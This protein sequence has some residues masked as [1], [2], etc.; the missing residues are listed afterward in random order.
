M[1]HEARQPLIFQRA[2]I[3]LRRRA[4][5]RRSTGRVA[6]VVC[7]LVAIVR[8][9]GPSA[10]AQTSACSQPTERS[11]QSHAWAIMA[12][13]V[14]RVDAGACVLVHAPPRT[15]T[16]AA[17][18]GYVQFA[19]T[20][21]E[22]PVALAA[23]ENTVYVVFQQPGA[24]GTTEVRIRSLD[25]VP[26]GLSW[27]YLPPDRL[28]AYPTLVKT[29]N[30]I[31]AAAHDDTVLLLRQQAD[32]QHAADAL[33][34][35]Q[36]CSI[37]LP[38]DA[39]KQWFAWGTSEAV[40]VGEHE[41][42]SL[43]TWKL[44][45]DQAGGL[46]WIAAGDY[47]IGRA[48]SLFSVGSTIAA[49]DVEG[50]RGSAWTL[51]RDAEP[52]RVGTLAVPPATTLMPL[53]AQG[54][55]LLSLHWTRERAEGGAREYPRVEVRELSLGTGVLLFDGPVP[56]N[57][58]LSAGEFRLLAMMLVALLIGVLVIVLKGDLDQD[59]VPLPPDTAMAGAGRRLL[60]T[61]IDLAIV[62]N[63]TAV[64][65][66]V[67]ASEILS[68]TVLLQPGGA[69][70]SIPATFVIGAILGTLFEWGFGRTPGKF[71][72]G[73]RVIRVGAKDGARLGFGGCLIRNSIK[74][75]MPPVAALAAVDENSRHRGDQLAHAAVV[76]DLEPEAPA[77]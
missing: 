16:N 65:Y 71:L 59:A 6:R 55:R 21:E 3:A 7:L 40:L 61:L 49:I 36:W 74:W 75:I 12:D 76:I 15:G 67:Q 14:D 39:K 32:G 33:T 19:R 10:L 50:G 29:G 63:L 4:S 44:A 34:E 27:D 72:A 31:S 41:N 37:D 18:V 20:F 66:G 53:F 5:V 38:G 64:L 22:W 13:H 43:H 73:C 42:G 77:E 68:L 26:L 2:L 45:R 9:A 46:S 70:S 28:E 17:S 25:T 24:R 23:W 11:Q 30:V 35:D 52:L 60:A 51:L 47:S 62:A 48:Q 57:E 8:F 1:K 58:V 69:W 56:R 54:P